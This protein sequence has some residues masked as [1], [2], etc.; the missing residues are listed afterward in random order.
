MAHDRLGNHEEALTAFD[1]ALEI[2]PKVGVK[3]K[4]DAIRK[5]LSVKK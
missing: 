2:N 1:A 4:A 3:R 5:R